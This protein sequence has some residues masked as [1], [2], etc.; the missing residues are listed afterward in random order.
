MS[1]AFDFVGTNVG[2]GTKTYNINFLKEIELL[3]LRE[4]IIIFLTKNYFQQLKKQKQN[5][6]IRYIIK[7][8]FFSNIFFRLFWMQFIFPFELK[9]NGVK[10]L[11]SPMNFCPIFLKIFKIKII[12][13]LHSNLPWVYFHLMPGNMLRNFFTKKLME[14]SI[15]SC[16]L[17]LVDSH[18]AK[19][20]IT[21][22]LKINIKKIKVV[23]LGIDKKF[24]SNDCE[25][26]FIKSF[27]YNEKYI[28]SVLS[29]VK[30][31]NILNMLKAFKI[32]VSDN[33]YDIKLVLVLQI[34]D[35]EYFS[36]INKY[37]NTN[38]DK[39]K[40]II[41]N[42]V[43]SESLPNLYKHSQLYIFSSYCEVFGL[44]SLEAMS[45][46]CPILISN[47]SALPEIND[48]AAD[49][50]DPDNVMD[51]KDKIQKIIF[52]EKHKNE[53]VEKGQNHFKKFTWNNNV[54]ITLDHIYNL[55]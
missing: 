26:N 35:R 42:D 11:Y 7:S 52:D 47:T 25:N 5:P 37:I 9:I 1:I 18:F 4:D 2:S 21:N 41:I 27:N 43:K 54:N 45:Q 8:N 29:C 20:E 23:Y 16:N 55:N 46:G 12:L 28:I 53:L 31:H 49:Y 6:K 33:N 30:Y 19:Q 40:I 50:F 36:E 3:S 10:K 13:T 14:L 17:L 48:I 39:N 15:N 51:I 32:L 22:I 38:F 24:L 44:T 34:L